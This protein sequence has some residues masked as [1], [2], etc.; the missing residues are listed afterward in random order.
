MTR[1]EAKQIKPGAMVAWRDPDNQPDNPS[2]DCSR[3]LC[4][5]S[6]RV[7]GDV[8]TIEDED[9]SVVECCPGELS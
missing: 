4:V 7:N 6:A 1:D 8:V 2:V 9:G 5:K 3:V